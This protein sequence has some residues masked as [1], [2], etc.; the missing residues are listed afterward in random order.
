MILYTPLSEHDIFPVD[1]Q[2]YEQFKWV[3]V[4]GKMIKVQKQNDGSYT[5]LQFLSTNPQDYLNTSYIPGQQ[6]YL[7]ESDS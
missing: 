2:E 5:I 1:D 3:E 6:I 7:N 4:E